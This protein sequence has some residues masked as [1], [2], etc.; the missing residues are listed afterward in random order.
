MVERFTHYSKINVKQFANINI[1]N[2]K[3]VNYGKE[4]INWRLSCNRY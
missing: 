4:Q 2:I 1:N 3:E